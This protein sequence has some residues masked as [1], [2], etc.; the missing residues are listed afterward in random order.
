MRISDR[1]RSPGPVRA[2]ATGVLVALLALSGPVSA[3]PR[4]EDE[5]SVVRVFTLKHRTGEEAAAVAGP[6]LTERGSLLLQSRSRALTV[7][8]T[9]GA[10][11]RVARALAALDQ[12]PRGL[13]I[14]VTLLK[15]SP[16][17][18]RERPAGR[19]SDEIRV[20]G[21]RLKKLLNVSSVTPLDSVVVQGVEGSAVAYSLGKEFR[22]EFLP[23]AAGDDSRV[24]LKN[25][26]LSR[27][28]SEG[29]SEV[30]HD[31]IRTTINVPLHQTY[32]LGIG[33]DGS[34]AGAL[35]LV[36]VATERGPGPGIAGIR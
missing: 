20:V 5:V 14:S 31:L 28:R 23:E 4:S 29:K 26:V 34:A 11:D 22:L 1:R 17:S 3:S 18:A 6:L 12:P 24:K 27:T 15:T 21:E 19:V 16:T 36:F 35:F 2:A 32:V 33:R 13:S 10:V 25:L 30:S 8:D 7:R 9:R